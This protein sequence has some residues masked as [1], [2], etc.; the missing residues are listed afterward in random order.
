MPA[1]PKRDKQRPNRDPQERTL[2][3]NNADDKIQE[4]LASEEA[5]QLT[6]DTELET[7]RVFSAKSEQSTVTRES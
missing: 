1:T 2:S 6:G 4:Q 7:K 5:R 3:N